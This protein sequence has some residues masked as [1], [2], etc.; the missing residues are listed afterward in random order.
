MVNFVL[1]RVGIVKN[2]HA[3]I[4]RLCRHCPENMYHIKIVFENVQIAKSE[5]GNLHNSQYG[6]YNVFSFVLRWFCRQ[7]LRL[8]FKVIFIF[9]AS[10]FL[11][12]VCIYDADYFSAVQSKMHYN[13]NFLSWNYH[14]LRNLIPNKLH[15]CSAIQL[16]EIS[17]ADARRWIPSILL[18]SMFWKLQNLFL[19]EK[20]G[21]RNGINCKTYSF[22]S[23]LRRWCP[24]HLRGLRVFNTAVVFF[25]KRGKW[26]LERT[27][28]SSFK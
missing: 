13:C 18:R 22:Y 6:K 25:Q 24:S 15:F 5:R 8:K 17:I 1:D 4:G 2:V 23:N 12:W 7:M 3:A 26:S 16:F 11:T 28:N 19:V 9:W 14:A 27:G 10:K 21:Y 20:H